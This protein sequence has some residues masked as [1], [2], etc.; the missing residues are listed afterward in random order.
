MNTFLNKTAFT[1]S[2]TH[3]FLF[4]VEVE[5]DSRVL[6]GSLCNTQNHGIFN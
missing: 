3:S 4:V 2:A 6:Y 1:I 5:G